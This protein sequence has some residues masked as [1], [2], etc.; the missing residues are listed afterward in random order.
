[1]C[2]LFGALAWHNNVAGTGLSKWVHLFCGQWFDMM[3][4]PILQ[5]CFVMM[6]APQVASGVL[7]AVIGNACSMLNGLC[8]SCPYPL[9]SSSSAKAYPN[10]AAGPPFPCLSSLHVLVLHKCLV[11]VNVKRACPRQDCM[12]ASYAVLWQGWFQCTLIVWLMHEN[13]HT[14]HSH[15]MGVESIAVLID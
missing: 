13:M 9:A 8:V 4:T 11:N 6:G 10:L 7:S 15:P 2:Q 14:G 5:H 3:G 1:M 12:T